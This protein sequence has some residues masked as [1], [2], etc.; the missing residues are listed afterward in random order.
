M[1]QIPESGDVRVIVVAA[2]LCTTMVILAVT[3]RPSRAES[4]RGEDAKHDRVAAGLQVLYG[5]HSVNTGLVTDSAGTGEPINLVIAESVARYSAS[6][7]EVVG[8]TLI[9]S[10]SPATRLIEAVRQSGAITIEAWLRPAAVNQT[11]PA[12]I[13]T[14]SRNPNERNFT[15]GQD[16]DKFEVRLRT[17]ET[18]SNGIPPV[19]SKPKSLTAEMTQV[20]YTREPAGKARIYVNGKLDVE[21]AVGGA[22]NNWDTSLHLALANELTGD[23][24][25][26]GVLRLVA[27]YNRALSADEVLQNFQVGAPDGAEA[28]TIADAT[29]DSRQFETQIAPLIARHCLECHDT[30]TKK[31]N[32]DL[33]RRA[34][35]L[36]GGEGGPVLVPGKADESP[37]WQLVETDEMPQKRSPLRPDEKKVLREWL[38]AGAAWSLDVIDP[39]VYAHGDGANRIFVQRLTVPEY[40]ET[41]RSTLGVDIAAESRE[42]LPRDLRA[43]G[44]SNT[45]YNLNVDLSHVEAYSKLAEIIVGR[46]DVKA[47]A[48]PYTTSRELTDENLTTVIEPVGRLLLRGPLSKAEVA[49]YCG[50]STTIAGTGGDFEEAIRYILE[51]MLQSPRFLYRIEQQRGDGSARPLDPFPLASRLS[52]ILWGGPPDGELFAAAEKGKLDRSGV[53]EQARRMLQDVRAIQRSRQFIAEWLNLDRLENLRP[54]P[55]KFPNWDPELGADMRAETLAFFEEVIWKQNRPLAD[56]LNAKV[57]FLTPRLAKHYGLA[58]A[59]QSGDGMVRYDLTSD[60]SRGGLLTQGS[61]LTVGGD[62]AS[63]VTRGLFL[64]HELLRGV[65]RDPPPCVDTRPVPSKPGLTQRMVSE[66]RIANK[67]CAGCHAKFEPPAFALE[68]FD[69]LGQYHETDEHGNRLRDDGLVLFPGDDKPVAYQSAAELM[70]LLSTS[71]RVRETFTWKLTQFALGRPLGAHDARSV[72]EIHRQARQ[73][74]GTYASLLTAIVTSDLVLMSHTEALSAASPK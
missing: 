25:W 11:G 42:I 48:T 62:N 46:V 70:N 55:E 24:P 69:G 16:G 35:A 45:A 7:L 9:R 66:S 19:V 56:L 73:G 71:D 21:Q 34:A 12:R 67:S 74:G 61:V 33:S 26:L 53:E 10:E 22:T 1:R 51:E 72:A 65:V 32:L 64:M 18:S 40:V 50:I 4:T 14:L 57:T 2:C 29:R 36:S 27:I 17:S 5:F 68:K 52:Y 3:S 43:D 58:P 6:G 23:R 44:F 49:R 8:K 30:L 39:A 59:Q 28:K 13:V 20:V 38:D 63:M 47:L 31:G 41:V 54:N 60:P 15:L 37:L